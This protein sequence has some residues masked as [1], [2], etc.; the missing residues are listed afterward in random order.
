MLT[1]STNVKGLDVPVPVGGSTAGSA[2]SAG[3]S[4]SMEHEY[5]FQ[6]AVGSES[7][8]GGRSAAAVCRSAAGARALAVGVGNDGTDATAT[9]A[10]ACRQ[11]G[12]RARRHRGKYRCF[13][14]RA[15]ATRRPGTR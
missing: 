5:G 2:G 10:A 8:S 7:D 12:G 1:W 3:G 15:L 6:D 9:G 4:I 14:T 11:G 13:A